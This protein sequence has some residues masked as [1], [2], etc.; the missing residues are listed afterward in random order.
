MDDLGRH[1]DRSTFPLSK[2]FGPK[3]TEGIERDCTGLGGGDVDAFSSK[4]DVKS[5]EVVDSFGVPLLPLAYSLSVVPTMWD[6]SDRKLCD[7]A[8]LFP[9]FPKAIDAEAASYA[10]C[11]MRSRFAGGSD[12]SVGSDRRFP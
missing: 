1:L 3:T 7:L 8:L 4:E 10:L 11:V 6:P 12:I 5:V 9:R 2:T